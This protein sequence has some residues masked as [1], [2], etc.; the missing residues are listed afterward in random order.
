MKR[1]EALKHTA[2]LGG[3]AALSASFLSLL[4]SC[5]QQPRIDWQP[6]FL[7]ESHAQLVTALIDTILPTTDTP[8]GL[9]VK[10]DVFVDLVYDQLLDE[11]GQKNIMSQMDQFNEKCVS[12]F[13]KVF[14]ELNA[15]QKI[16][17]LQE[18]EANS[19]KFGR[20]VWGYTVEKLPDPGFYRSFKATAIQG[21][22]TSAEVGKSV[23]KYDP[24]PGPFQGCIPLDEIG[25]VWSY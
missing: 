16:G 3:T 4:Q 7:S 15:E 22:F 5:Q 20:G 18:E 24:I 11:T 19:P 2:L 8:G 14:H 25:K 10:V 23:T 17:L 21:Y 9:D 12:R 13:G 6:R 1:R